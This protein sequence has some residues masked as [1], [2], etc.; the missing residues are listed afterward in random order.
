MVDDVKELLRAQTLELESTFKKFI[1][2]E[3]APLRAE[4]Q[5]L[6]DSVSFINSKYDDLLK[7]IECL[8]NKVASHAPLKAEIKEIKTS[9]IK[10]EIITDSKEQWA[11]RS[12]IEILGIPEKKGENLL[13]L[14]EKVTALSGISINTKTD[15][16]FITRVAPKD[17]DSNRPKA[18][19][20][21]FLARFKKD[22]CLVNLKKMKNLKACDVGY[23]GSNSSIYFNEHLTSRNKALLRDAKK[24]KAEKN[25]KY[26]WVKNCC[27][28]ARKND[29][30]QVIHIANPADLK[31]IV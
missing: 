21:R 25:Y 13:E 24:L 9:T 27:I 14:L 23:H 10:A 29:T 5:E 1:R 6:K 15:I 28:F 12:N 8:E 3:L 7:R 17:S 18:I 19:V 16:D 11:R 26:V 20:V 31:K 2:D 4:L 22:D 30:S